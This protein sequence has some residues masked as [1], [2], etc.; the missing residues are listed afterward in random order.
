MIQPNP[1]TVSNLTDAVALDV[2]LIHSCAVR[3]TGEVVCQRDMAH[4]SRVKSIQTFAGKPGLIA[5]A[6]TDGTI[7]VWRW[8]R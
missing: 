7:C 3:Q 5:T 2:G 4:Q 6:S 1:T 8:T